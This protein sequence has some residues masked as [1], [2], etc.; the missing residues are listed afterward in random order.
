MVKFDSATRMPVSWKGYPVNF[1]DIE[2]LPD[3]ERSVMIA[4]TFAKK[5]GGVAVM[6]KRGE[7]ISSVELPD[8]S[9]FVL[10]LAP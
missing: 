10:V 1:V 8:M 6:N 5:S 4:P 9:P 2:P 7:L 3:S